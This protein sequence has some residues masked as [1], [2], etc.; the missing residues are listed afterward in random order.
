MRSFIKLNIRDI[1]E[2]TIFINPQK[3]ISV[4]IMESSAKIHCEGK[5]SYNIYFDQ[6]MAKVE[7]MNAIDNITN[8]Y[9][10]NEQ[11]SSIG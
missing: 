6:D 7:F 11:N 1:R 5:L 3:I 2:S 8:I 4:E 9:T 10:I